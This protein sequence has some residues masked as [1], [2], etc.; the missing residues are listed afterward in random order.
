MLERLDSVRLVTGETMEVYLLIPPVGEWMER[1]ISFT[2][3]Y[4]DQP[5]RD[6]IQRLRG[7][8]AGACD[9]FYF[10]GLINEQ[11]AGQVWY[12]YARKSDG[13]ANFGN[14]YTAPAHRKKGITGILMKYFSEN[15]KKSEARAAFCTCLSPWVVSIYAKHG[16]HPALPGTD[17]GPLMLS[18][19]GVTTDFEQFCNEYYSVKPQEKLTVAQADIRQRH[20]IDTLLKFYTKLN[21]EKSWPRI[22]LASSIKNYQHA[23]H[24]TEEGRGKLFAAVT[25]DARVVGWSFC[26]NPA[27]ELERKTGVI[28]YEIHPNYTGFAPTLLMETVK[29]SRESF[30][31]ICAQL[32]SFAVAKCK[33][34]IE[35]GFTEISLLPQYGYYNE[36]NF[37]LKIFKI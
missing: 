5:R 30:D 21:P 9:D 35:A 2:E 16:F 33:A 15:F 1:M 27:S 29:A 37:D 22:A 36:Q 6:I 19:K 34:F 7:D 23:L 25:D 24:L 13:V 18:Q 10:L 20:S 11:V 28:D 17:C 14:V 26:L 4:S 3:H 32:P 31:F 8:Y 12:G